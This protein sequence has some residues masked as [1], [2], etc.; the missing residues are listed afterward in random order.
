MKHLLKVLIVLFFLFLVSTACNEE[1]TIEVNSVDYE[2]SMEKGTEQIIK[3]T[4]SDL[5]SGEGKITITSSD[6][7]IISVENN[8]IK[9]LKEGESNITI[10]IK[11][12]DKVLKTLTEK[13]SVYQV[14]YK[15]SYELDGG[16]DKTSLIKEFNKGEEVKL[17]NTEKEGFVFLG[18]TLEKGNTDYILDTKGLNS[19]VTLYA[20]F[21]K[22]GFKVEYDLDG[23]DLNNL[24][25]SIEYG[26]ELVLN[27]PEK[28]GYTFIGWKLND[29]ESFITKIDK[30][31]SDITLK[32]YYQLTSYKITYDLDGGVIES[33]VELPKEITY[34]ETL[35]LS[36][37]YKEG[38]KF[39][40]W[41]TKPNE[42]TDFIKLIKNISSDITI[43]ANYKKMIY[44]ISYDLD[45]GVL[46]N[47]ITEAE[48][49]VTVELGKPV[50]EGYIF[51]GWNINNSYSYYEKIESIKEDCE[52]LAVFEEINSKVTFNLNESTV[53]IDLID[54]IFYTETF[55][56]PI[57]TKKNYTF[58]GWSLVENGTEYVTKLEK[59]IKDVQ[60][61]AN[62]ELNKYSIKYELNGGT[63]NTL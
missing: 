50:K 33:Q 18:W 43:Y 45:G 39:L 11:L 24:I 57:P 47:L 14:K 37:P 16:E 15:I 53:N 19:D 52:L 34:L 4:L 5:T 3:Y 40:G 17:T 61:F 1:K 56:L 8:K 49:G 54:N 32:A 35:V 21:E 20:N 23:G 28:E 63:C 46:D 2:L 25:T 42:T 44:T 27:N 36:S 31:E 60:L 41:S 12:N 6:N 9:A 10:E 48:Y 7:E 62:F 26:S 58:L 30:V 51:L 29:G 55:V 38:Y 59:I 13:I 22:K